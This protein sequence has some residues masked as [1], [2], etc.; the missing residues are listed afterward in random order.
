MKKRRAAK[1][2]IPPTAST[3]VA[4]NPS[5]KAL[6]SRSA[7][8]PDY[9]ILF[10]DKEEGHAMAAASVARAWVAVGWERQRRR[11]PAPNERITARRKK[12]SRTARQNFRR[13]FFEV[14]KKETIDKIYADLDENSAANTSSAYSPTS[15]TP[16]PGYHKLTHGETK[17]ARSKPAT[18]FYSTATARGTA[19]APIP[20]CLRMVLAVLFGF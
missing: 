18:G 2:F 7:P 3:A 8:T 1:P 10:A 4:R 9:C 13:R 5:P 16:T 12:S 11:L 6:E 15:P 17:D 19:T 20:P 14:S